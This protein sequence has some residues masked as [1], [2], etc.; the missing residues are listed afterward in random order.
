MSLV[1]QLHEARA[2]FEAVQRRLQEL[3]NNPQLQKL[4]AFEAEQRELLAKYGMSLVD[5]NT[6][7]DPNYVPPVVEVKE[8]KPKKAGPNTVFTE[9]KNPHTGEVVRAAN[10]LKKK[11]QEW[12][13]KYGKDE[14]LSW[15]QVS[16]AA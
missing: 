5:V 4:Q 8:K 13:G 12:I 3:E 7:L 11:I 15:K 10:I 14:V 1:K 16:A 9:Y 2:E 6:I